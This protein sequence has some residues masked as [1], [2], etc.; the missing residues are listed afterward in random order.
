[1]K[2]EIY[3]SYIFLKIKATTIPCGGGLYLHKCPRWR[4]SIVSYLRLSRDEVKQEGK[5]GIDKKYLR[6]FRG[7]NIKE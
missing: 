3:L 4:Q 6:V 2:K 5:E 7:K 1:M